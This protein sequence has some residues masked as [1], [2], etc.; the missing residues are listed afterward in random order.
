MAPKPTGTYYLAVQDEVCECFLIN[1]VQAV[2]DRQARQAPPAVA[3][4]PVHT[5][6]DRPHTWSCQQFNHTHSLTATKSDK[7]DTLDLPTARAHTPTHVLQLLRPA[8]EPAAAR[9]PLTQPA[10]HQ[11]HARNSRYSVHWPRLPPGHCLPWQ[12]RLCSLT[13]NQHSQL[14]QTW[15][16]KA[17]TTKTNPAHT[18]TDASHTTHHH[19]TRSLSAASSL[20]ARLRAPMQ[21]N[22]WPACDSLPAAPPGA[23]HTGRR[24]WRVRDS[25]CAACRC[26]ICQVLVL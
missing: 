13:V 15:K 18:H 20:P 2:Q 16:R 23:Q 5:R 25:I 22:T 24:S 1:P 10:Q 14:V 4:L 12:K 8:V 6:T 3:H 11:Q 19:A 7:T 26:Q 9:L 17:Q 21:V